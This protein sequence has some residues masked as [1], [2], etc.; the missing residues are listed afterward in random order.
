MSPETVG[1][2]FRLTLTM[3]RR[4]INTYQT[5]R[6]IAKSSKSERVGEVTVICVTRIIVSSMVFTVSFT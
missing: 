4:L 5:V 2:D 6:S 3:T 1:R